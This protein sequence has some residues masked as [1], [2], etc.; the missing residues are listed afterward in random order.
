VAKRTPLK[1]TTVDREPE[2]FQQDS[3][4]SLLLQ[5]LEEKPLVPFQNSLLN[6]RI[7]YFALRWKILI[8]ITS[9]LISNNHKKNAHVKSQNESQNES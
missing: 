9:F 8:D 1:S 5:P 2:A 6:F 4:G 7:R 3:S